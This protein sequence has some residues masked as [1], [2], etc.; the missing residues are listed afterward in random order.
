MT[1]QINGPLMATPVRSLAFEDQCYNWS[2]WCQSTVTGCDSE[3][4]P[5]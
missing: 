3:T 1:G 4:D 2:A 5:Q